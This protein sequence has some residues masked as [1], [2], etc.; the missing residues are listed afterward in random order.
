MKAGK[1]QLRAVDFE[2]YPELQELARKYGM[3]NHCKKVILKKI[4]KLS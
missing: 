3:V 2:D 4:E 1:M